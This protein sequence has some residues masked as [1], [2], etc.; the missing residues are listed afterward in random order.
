MKV[1]LLNNA[2]R[3]VMLNT[4]E[5]EIRLL[6]NEHTICDVED[7]ENLHDAV[8]KILSHMRQ[9][10]ELVIMCA[11]GSEWVPEGEDKVDRTSL[12]AKNEIAPTS[13]SPKPEVPAF[14]EEEPA[15]AIA[16]Q[17]LGGG[18]HGNAKESKKT[19]ASTDDVL[20]LRNWLSI[21]K[22][23]SVKTAIEDRL[24]ELG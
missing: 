4:A 7:L 5:K 22:R 12:K 9:T 8:P 6:P 16:P 18:L 13:A 24:A 15:K 19:I 3:I 20:L 14:E 10:G 17:P 11:D 23:T 1:T 21:E 2:P